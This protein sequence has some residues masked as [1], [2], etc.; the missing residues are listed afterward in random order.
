[1]KRVSFYPLKFSTKRF[2]F[3]IG[4]ICIVLSTFFILKKIIYRY[5]ITHATYF[6]DPEKKLHLAQKLVP[7]KKALPRQ[8]EWKELYDYQAMVE[9]PYQ[10]STMSIFE[11]YSA[12]MPLFLPS[13]AF[14]KTL[15]QEKTS[16]PHPELKRILSEV[17]NTP[18]NPIDLDKED[19][20]LDLNDPK[21]LDKWISLADFYDPENMPYI[22]YFDSF[23]HLK[24]LLLQ[25]NFYKISENM[26][27][28]NEKRKKYAYDQW[29]F[30]L[31]E[32]KKQLGKKESDSLRFFNLDLHTSVIADLKFIFN[33]LGHTITNWSISAHNHIFKQENASVQVVNAASWHH[34]D[35]K[36][37]DEFYEYYKDTLNQYDAFIVTHT[38]CFSFLYEKTGKPII[39][40]NSTR[41][42]Q[43]FSNQPEKWEW[44]NNYLIQGVKEKRI[45]IVSNNKGDQAYLKYFTHLDSVWIPSLCL[46]TASQYTGKKDLSLIK[47]FRK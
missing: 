44:L 5:S 1:M 4:F 30:I 17:I 3:L 29:Q 21:V 9:I 36:M 38:P 39:I 34:L 15:Y 23:E 20:F 11:I 8:Y 7:L 26:K 25:S 31:T 18:I 13:K 47:V 16:T 19:L 43:P 22:Q 12:N 41:Y 28:F 24:N 10:I 40:V 37:C 35:A 32:V 6:Y 42:E 14:L 33:D 46:Y 45:F 27:V 2:F